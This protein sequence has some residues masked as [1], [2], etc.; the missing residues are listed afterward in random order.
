MDVA[1]PLQVFSE[2]AGFG[3]PYRTA[4]VALGPAVRTAQ[5]LVL[6]ELEGLPDDVGPGDRVLVPGYPLAT[7]RPPPQLLSWL[8]RVAR[9]G[10]EV[11]SV[12][13]GAFA[14]G[15]AGLLDGR[16]CTTHWRRVGELAARFPAAQVLGERLFVQDGPIVTSAGVSAGVDLAL[17]LLERDGGPVL[18]SHVARE[19]VVYLRRDGAH[20]QE[21]VYLDYQ[22][23]LSPGVH[24]VQQYL[25]S[26]PDSRA[27]LAEL[28]RMAALSE[29]TLTRQFRQATGISVQQYRARLR[30]ERARDLLRNPALTVEAVAEACGFADAR[31]LRRLWAAAHGGASPRAGRSP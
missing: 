13:T 11:G 12:C 21:S 29:R 8:R 30:L 20:A 1:G 28:G 3:H 18:A 19:M 23:H 31:Q 15:E 22:T 2:A 27:S 14:L 10:A 26:H 4:S 17:A 7:A 24:R 9:A 5:G 6:S 16:R 25:V